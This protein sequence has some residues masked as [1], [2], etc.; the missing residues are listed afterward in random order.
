GLMKVALVA[1]VAMKPQQRH[2]RR[3]VT[4]WR[5][6]IESALEAGD[7]FLVILGGEEKSATLLVKKAL[8]DHIG[9]R[10]RM[11]KVL[12]VERGLIGVQHRVGEDRVVLEIGIE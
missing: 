6:S 4:R 8:E 7:K 9:E 1:G 10:A 5:R 3:A 2:H 11:R 12:R